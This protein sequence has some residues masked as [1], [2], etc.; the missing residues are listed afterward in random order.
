MKKIRLIFILLFSSSSL[1]AQSMMDSVFLL[2]DSVK[3]FTL[4]N[5]YSA[6]LQFHPIVKQ[7]RLLRDNAQAEIR[8]A[9]GSFDP[10]LSASFNNKKFNNKDYYTKWTTSLSLPTWFP[11]DPK[12]G[13]DQNSGAF[14]DPE[15]S[16][17]SSD[18][19]KQVFAG[20]SLPLGRGLFT[21]DRRTALKTAKIFAQMAEAE[22]IKLINKIL[23]EAAKEYWQWYYSYYNFRLYQ[24][25]TLIAVELF[26]RAKLNATHGEASAV[27]TVQAK[28]TMQ[29]RLVERQ[30]AYLDFLNTGIRISNY[31]W[32]NVAEPV[33][34]SPNIAPVLL[35]NGDELLSLSTLET[36]TER[37]KQYHPELVKLNLKLDQLDMER[38]LT[39][40]YLK[41]RLDLNYTFL[42]QPIS[43]QGNFSTFSLGNN[44]KFGLDFSVPVLLRKERGKL[45]QAKIKIKGTE[46]ELAQTQ[47]EIINQVNT[48]FNQLKNTRLMLDQQRGIAE[49]YERLLRAELLNF[50]NGEADLF[51]INLQQEKLIQSQSKLLKMRSEYE[52]LKASLYWAAGVKDL[53]FD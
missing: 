42:N 45:A 8:L 9:R 6:I 24:R 50:E 2:P 28:I 17:P 11:V 27:D 22:Q 25:N 18:N 19:F 44:Y 52:K 40:E 21:D 31:L 23:L 47:R 39:T 3:A 16:V 29:Q 20:V 13:V 37:A 1:F 32:S 53:S 14:I 7:T 33:Q 36:L 34:L 4:E 51:K 38:K 10:K 41:P 5:F 15:N 43:P 48:T 46:F 26:R 35:P 12:I 30:E 49:N